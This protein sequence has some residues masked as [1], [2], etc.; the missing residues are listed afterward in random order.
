MH[1]ASYPIWLKVEVVHVDLA[2]VVTVAL[3]D[4]LPIACRQLNDI[5]W[6]NLLVITCDTPRIR[7]RP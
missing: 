3:N 6:F 1:T 2:R 5:P 4:S 7:D